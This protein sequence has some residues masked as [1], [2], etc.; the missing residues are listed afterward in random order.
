[1]TEIDLSEVARSAQ[2]EVLERA[3]AQVQASLDLGAGPLLRAVLFELGAG[4]AQ[5]L[6]LV[7]HH[8]VIDGVS[9]RILLEEMRQGYLKAAGAI[10]EGVG[11]CGVVCG[12]GGAAVGVRRV[13]S[14]AGA[15]Q[16]W[17]EVEQAV[18]SSG[19]RVTWKEKEPDKKRMRSRCKW[20]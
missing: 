18:D 19:C 5:R 15:G 4:Q 2:R 1:M 16:Y 11:G 10:A 6:L 7:A 14:S 13:G 9:W 8:L 3:A 20:S 12:L 17:N